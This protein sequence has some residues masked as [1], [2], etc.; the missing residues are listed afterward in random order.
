MDDKA[1]FEKLLSLGET[2]L[3]YFYWKLDTLVSCNWKT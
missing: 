2:Q 3:V 1:R